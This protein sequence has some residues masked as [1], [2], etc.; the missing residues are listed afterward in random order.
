MHITQGFLLLFTV[1]LIIM[2]NVNIE[3]K[4]PP[5]SRNGNKAE[6][7]VNSKPSKD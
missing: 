2:L 4:L 1:F 6:V 5:G 7:K 3:Y